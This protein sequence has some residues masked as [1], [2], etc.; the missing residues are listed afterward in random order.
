MKQ[1]FAFAVLLASAGCPSDDPPPEENPPQLW[2][3]LNGSERAVRLVPY[4]PEPF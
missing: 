1:L 3:A 4:Q 2:L